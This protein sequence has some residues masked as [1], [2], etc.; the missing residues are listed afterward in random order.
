MS[1]IIGMVSVVGVEAYI[2]STFF[3]TMFLV[4]FFGIVHS[5]VFLPVA[6]TIIL[7]ATEQTCDYIHKQHK[8]RRN[9]DL[10]HSASRPTT[11]VNSGGVA[12]EANG[13]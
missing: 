2:I 6:L 3:K 11:M 4:F 8:L 13:R 10:V 12:A 1:T 7:P 5:L 9:A